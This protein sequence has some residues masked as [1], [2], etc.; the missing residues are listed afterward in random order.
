M[1]P[2]DVISLTDLIKSNLKA[3]A[4]RKEQMKKLNEMLADLLE[5]DPVYREHE[6]AAKE[7]AKIKSKTKNQILKTPQAADLASKVQALRNEL[8][9]LNQMQS[10]YLTDYAKTGAT[11]FEDEDGKTLEIVYT[12]KLVNR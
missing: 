3:I 11:S 10:V 1:D 12:A 8:K 5:N 7:A 4:E 6:A 9:E 2:N